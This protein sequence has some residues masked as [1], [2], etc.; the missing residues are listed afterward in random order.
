MAFGPL[1]VIIV[2]LINMVIF[3]FIFGGLARLPSEGVPYP[4]FTYVAILPWQF[5]ANATRR[6]SESLVQQKNVI[7]KVYFPRLVI[8]LASVLSALVDFFA[9]F[10]VL[11]VILAVYKVMPTWQILTLPFFLLLA[12]GAG[13]GVGL[14]LAGLAVKFHDVKLGIG[15]ALTVWQFLTPVAYSATLIPESWQ[16]FYRLNPMTTVVEGFRWAL[17][18][19][20][21]LHGWISAITAV[22]VLVLLISGAFYFRRTERTIVDMI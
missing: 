14:W 1:W 17:L 22:M 9:S 13:L 21:H 18:N 20:G 11:V 8:P 6:V 12:T 2:P 7:S 10:V 19:T 16:M 15:F 3:S 4:L 5:F